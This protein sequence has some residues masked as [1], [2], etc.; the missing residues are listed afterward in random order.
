MK[1]HGGK[2]FTPTH[3]R[4][5]GGVKRSKYFFLKV[6]MLHIKLKG[7][8]HRARGIEH[9]P[10]TYSVF[11]HTLRPRGIVKT[12]FLKVVMLHIKLN[13]IASSTKQA[14]ILSLHIPVALV[15]PSKHF[16]LKVV[17]LHIKLKG[18][19]RR[20]PCKHIFCP[21]THP[22]PMG[23][24]KNILLSLVKLHI[25]LKGKKY[26]PTCKQKLWPYTHP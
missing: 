14:H 19:E 2:Y 22:L 7:M 1:Q 18:M 6:V 15:V 13:Y 8:G 5:G 3:P 20:A 12:F 25:K 21:Y 17:M 24:D 23:S 16:F 26:R 11:T 9:H 4:P 10:S